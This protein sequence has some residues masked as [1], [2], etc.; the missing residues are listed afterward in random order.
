MVSGNFHKMKSWKSKEGA[1]Q[2]LKEGVYCA[3][4]LDKRQIIE[5]LFQGE[6]EE[7]NTKS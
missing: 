6:R 7:P 3:S 2:Q 1:A 4:A 5:E